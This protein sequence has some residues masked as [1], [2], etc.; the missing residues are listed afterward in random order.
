VD[1]VLA[2]QRHRPHRVL[3]Q[4]VAQ[5]QLGILQEA[6]ELPPEG[7]GCSSPPCPTRWKARTR[8]GGPRPLCG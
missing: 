2:A 7:K 4:V 8:R 3:R 6:R 1:P 5:L